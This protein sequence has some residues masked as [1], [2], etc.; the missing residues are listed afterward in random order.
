M[1]PKAANIIVSLQAMQKAHPYMVIVETGTI[2]RI[3]LQYEQGDGHST[4]YIAQWMRDNE[5]EGEFYSI[6]LE[7]LQA[8]KYLTELGLIDYVEIITGDSAESLVTFKDIITFAY[9][10]SANDPDLILREFKTVWPKIVPGGCVMVDDCNIESAE[11]NKGD[12]LIPYL[13]ENG[14]EYAHLFDTNQIVI[15]KW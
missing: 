10:D 6:D 5:V 3:E 11:L 1:N 9:L 2:R 12:L 7:T 15:Y 4:L 8:K 14:I 13:A